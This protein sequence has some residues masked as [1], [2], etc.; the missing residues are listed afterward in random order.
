MKCPWYQRW[1]TAYADDELAGWRAMWL[2][3]HLVGCEHCAEELGK[4]RRM[5]HWIA[6][7]KSACIGKLDD[8]LFLQKLRVRLQNTE[9]AGESRG[10]SLF[11]SFSTR[12]LAF[13][14]VAVSLLVTA[15]IGGR[16]VFSPGGGMQ[17]AGELPLLP[18]LGGSKVEFK[19]LKVA[20]HLWAG[21]VRFSKPDV[22]IPVIWV[23][24]LTVAETEI[25]S[26]ANNGEGL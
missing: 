8:T 7:Q 4:L 11:G 16:L 19:D 6:S 2:H 3:R 14:A 10:L 12:R 13:A 23:N 20:K 17:L 24:G 9:P 22:D 15:V 18:P 26:P 5:R 1:L 25:D 21:E